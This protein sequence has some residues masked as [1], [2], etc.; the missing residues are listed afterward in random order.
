[1]GKTDQLTDITEVKKEYQ[2]SKDDARKKYDGKELTVL[3]TVMYRSA[4]NPTLRIGSRTNPELNTVPDVECQY[5]E[6]D[7]LF[8]N[9]SENQTIKVKGT[10]KVTDSGMEMKPCKFVPF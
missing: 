7:A 6:S 1:M 3:G 2:K 10:L 8:K 4:V 9:V 5:D